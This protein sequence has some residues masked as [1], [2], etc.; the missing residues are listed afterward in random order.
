MKKKNLSIFYEFTML[1]LLFCVCTSKPPVIILPGL[2]GSN[3]YATSSKHKSNHWYCSKSLNKTL[4]WVD[5]DYL[6]PP[7]INCFFEM[8]KGYYNPI[9]DKIENDPNVR[10]DV[11]DFGGV[12]GISYIDKKGIF[13]HHFIESFY[14]LVKKFE[15]HGY[16]A[17]KDLFGAPYDW[18]L[19]VAGIEETFYPQFK[20]LIETAYN[21]NENQKVTIVAYSC[22][23]LLSHR[24]LGKFADKE[25]KNKYIKK[26]IMLA[27]AFAGS[28]LTVD[29][30]WN[31]YF[32][33]LSFLRTKAI[34]EGV[35][36]SPAVHGLFPNHII[37]GDQEIIRTPQGEKITAK[38]L[39][40]FLI[41]HGKV[42]GDNIKMMMKSVE[43]SKE[44]PL[45]VG[46]P[47]YMIYN[48]GV[49]TDFALIFN[50]GYDNKPSRSIV[51]GDG[52]VPSEGPIWGCKTWST[53]SA[54]ICH[55]VNSKSDKFD[56]VSL[57]RNPYIHDII[58]NNTIMDDWIEDKRTRFITS[59]RVEVNDEETEYFTIG[60]GK[61]I[62]QYK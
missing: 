21:Q 6:I 42:K 61:H 16:V 26:V 53:T 24:F 28:G 52:T 8:L 20:T 56:H 23:G 11:H 12:N 45:E 55:D 59:P 7:F 46:V 39:P 43:V 44:A 9:T 57:S 4:V 49:D 10:L 58:Y 47:I 2:Y 37:W 35:E 31:H 40:Q 29:I 41:D 18:R 14:H 34:S 54:V 22:G 19:A 5:Y 36:A 25:W 60:D 3:L 51:S 48:S 33:I 30:I 17:K 38:Q 50:K 13:G 1:S 27:P 62:I 15:K 32:P